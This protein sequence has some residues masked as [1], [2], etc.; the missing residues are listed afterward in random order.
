MEK[1]LGSFIQPMV[2]VRWK[3]GRSPAGMWRSMGCLF[4]QKKSGNPTDT[5]S[6]FRRYTGLNDFE[7]GTFY[8]TSVQTAIFL[9]V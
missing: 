1:P 8:E 4:P 5:E 7:G 2:G 6:S 3:A 9:L